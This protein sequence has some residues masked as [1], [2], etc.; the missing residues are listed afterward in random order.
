[1][2][3]IWNPCAQYT[4]SASTTMLPGS[5]FSQLSVF[6][7]PAFSSPPAPALAEAPA[8]SQSGAAADPTA[9]KPACA[10]P[11]CAKDDGGEEAGGKDAGWPPAAGAE[12]ALAG[13]P[14][15]PS[16]AE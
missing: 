8:S 12:G 14:A 4:L 3:K 2:P 15:L 5:P 9:C 6:G 10:R 16:G 7:A 11:T 13:E 1:M